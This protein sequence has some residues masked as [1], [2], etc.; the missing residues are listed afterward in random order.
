MRICPRCQLKY[1]DDNDRCFVDG[2][3]LEPMPDERIGTTLAGRYLIE[4]AIGEGG[5]ATV[6]RAR[7]TLVDRP[8]AI[9][10][11][12]KHLTKD[13][14]LRERFR[15]EAKNS[16]SLAHPNII[17]ILDTGE[18]EDGTAFMVM[19]L[20]NGASLGTIIEQQGAMAPAK[21][22]ELGLQI[23]RGLARA[24][25]FQVVHRD[26]KPDNIFLHRGR[27]GRTIVKLLDFGIARSLHD[28]RLTSA[29]ELFGTP[30][31]MAPERVM[32]IDAGPLADLYAVGIIFFEMLTGKLPFHADNLPGIL[33]KHMQEAPPA[34]SSL[35]PNI[36]RRLDELVMKLLAKKPEDRPVDAH[37]VIKEL[38]PLVPADVASDAMMP[39]PAVGIMRNVAPTLPPTTLERW[40]R[41]AAV[42]EQMLR[43]AYPGA[44]PPPDLVQALAQLK[45]VI[46]RI[47][48]LRSAGLKE[49]RKLDA[50]DSN[51]REARTRLGHAVDTLGVDLSSAREGARAARL[52]V[53]PYLDAD[54]SAQEA[55]V[56][57]HKRL[58][59]AGWHVGVASPTS[60]IV[61]AFR[62]TAETMD[63]WLLSHA[64]GAKAQVW[65]AQKEREVTDLDFQ[66]EALRA[67]RQRVEQT[68][69][70]EHAEIEKALIENGKQIEKLDQE[71]M[72]LGGQIAAP[73]RPRGE[74]GDLFAELET[75]R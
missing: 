30:Q 31:Y 34:L 73:L 16:A 22:A 1:P 38:L 27:D 23:A 9:K 19:E 28:S 48:E 65:I 60:E 3:T 53:Q 35:V 57:A 4:S 69:E 26:L 14:S 42:F 39:T 6:Y 68:F 25:D 59:E 50:L 37:Q 45:T 17:E 2:A 44:V 32:S 63:R 7:H 15:R 21:V 47:N 5:M 71:L 56:K 52:E 64:T 55:Y 72:A 54:R 41:R 40:A 8:V 58:I 20:L 75:D 74:L 62:E 29:G 66:V 67:Q 36:P 33:I 18:T 70:A 51:A 49:Q 24:H 61:Q 11:M 12:A 46:V 10:V 13:A 43:R